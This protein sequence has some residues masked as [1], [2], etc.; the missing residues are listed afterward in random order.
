LNH[1]GSLVVKPVPEL[2]A[3]RGEHYRL[4][5]VDIL[6][7]VSNLLEGV[8]GDALEIVAEFEPR[9]A[10]SLGVKLRCSPDRSEETLVVHDVGRGRVEIQPARS[11]LS[12]DIKSEPSW[13]P[14]DLTPGET[15]KLRLFLDRSVVEVFANDRV[16]LSFRIYPHRPD[17]LGLDLFSVG[18]GAKLKSLEVWQMK[19][20]WNDRTP[21]DHDHTG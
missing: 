5:D 10:D 13:A 16:C 2:K 19:P 8:W 15:L 4:A 11:S 18:G 7:G 3:L 9:D 6:P 21:P 17:S 14:L 1:D 20:I 12:P